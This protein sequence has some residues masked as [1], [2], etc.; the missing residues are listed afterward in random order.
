MPFAK[1]REL[2][3]QHQHY[4]PEQEDEINDLFALKMAVVAK[5]LS[6]ELTFLQQAVDTP[7]TFIDA[8]IDAFIARCK[9]RDTQQSSHINFRLNPNSLTN[10]LYRA[11]AIELFK[12]KNMAQILAIITPGIK[13]QLE[14]EIKH[15]SF[16]LETMQFVFEPISLEYLKEPVELE[17]LSN[18]VLADELLLKV[19]QLTEFSLTIHRT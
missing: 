13:N 19:V 17:S 2:I 5:E 14:Y 11:I 6:T 3:H 8:F 15:Q 18:C 4:L 10:R 12:P 7:E 9:E 1:I 16:N